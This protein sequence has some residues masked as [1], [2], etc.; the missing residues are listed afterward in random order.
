MNANALALCIGL[1]GASAPAPSVVLITV[2]TLRPD[3]LGWVAGRNATPEIDRLAAEGARFPGA[4]SPVPLT[5]P[6]HASLLTGLEPPR[7]ALPH[8]VLR[9]PLGTGVKLAAV[10]RA[11]REVLGDAA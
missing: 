1:A 6:A 4:I 7:H 8:H 3:A 5:L 9:Q 10:A 2:D 11:E